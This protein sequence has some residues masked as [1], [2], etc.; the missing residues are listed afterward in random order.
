MSECLESSCYFPTSGLSRRCYSLEWLV[1][2]LESKSV[3]RTSVQK[4]LLS[5]EWLFRRI[6]SIECCSHE[7]LVRKLL[8][9][10]VAC[11]EAVTRTS[12]LSGSCYLR[13]WLF[14]KIK[15]ASVI[16]A[17]GMALGC[18]W[19]EWLPEKKK[20]E[21]YSHMGL[22]RKLATRTSGFA[23]KSCYLHQWLVRKIV[24]AGV[25][26]KRGLSVG[27][28]LLLARVACPEYWR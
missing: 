9:A 3:T 22:V 13:D 16:R 7:W 10:R 1:Q 23:Q 2:E 24:S 15:S 25:A 4:L 28:G 21:F 20:Y 12:G 27:S 11:P 14:G 19:H 18:Y 8:L 5:H 6:E 26:R 17:S